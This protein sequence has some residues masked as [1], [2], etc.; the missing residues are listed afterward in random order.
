MF[1][2]N[3]DPVLFEL[4]FLEIRWYSLAYI[5]GILF[6]WWF[7]KYLIKVKFYDY[8]N[9]KLLKDFDDLVTI[10]IISIILGGRIGYIVF[11]NLE[12]YTNNP[13]EIVK[14][15]EGGM[16]FHGALIGIVIGT[17]L[18]S[19]K[20]GIKLFLLL[21]IIACA[22]P[23]GIFFGRIANFINSELVGK[24]TNVKWSVVFPII[25]LMKRHPSQIYE[26][27]LEGVILFIIMCI[28]VSKKNYKIGT[29]SIL[30]LISY[31]VFRIISEIFREPDVQIGYLFNFISMGALLS[32]L[33]ILTGTIIY[34][35]LKRNEK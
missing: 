16:S 22:S 20:K 19:V 6:G 18:F 27:I 14:V 23:I 21:D 35:Y 9:N 12:Y 34:F 24:V 7:G 1:I 10:L 31:G 11:Y 25:D 26:A 15:W 32:V 3:L 4:G 17:Y 28:V 33:M 29:C 8:Q 2:H 13:F 30:F 5:F